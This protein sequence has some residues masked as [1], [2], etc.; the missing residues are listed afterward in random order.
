MLQEV[1]KAASKITLAVSFTV[2]GHM[3]KPQ[4]NDP[5][6][7][8]LFSPCEDFNGNYYVKPYEFCKKHSEYF[9]KLERSEHHMLTFSPSEQ[10][11]LT[12]ESWGTIKNKL[13][14]ARSNCPGVTFGVAAYDIEYDYQPYRSVCQ[15]FDLVGPFGRVG[16][17]K[18][19]NGYLTKLSSADAFNKEQC[20]NVEIV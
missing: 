2:S 13:C 5:D 14:E 17:L 9:D 8:K 3:Y 16:F 20:L 4:G 12:F 7:Y 11:A 6:D 19:M 15:K 1:A 18:K 10:R